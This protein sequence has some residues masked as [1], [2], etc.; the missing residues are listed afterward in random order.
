MIYVINNSNNPFFNHAAEEYLINEFNEEISM[1]WINRPSIL[2]GRNQNTISEINLDYVK[3]NNI[4]VVRRLSGG[5]TVF[6]DLGNM[7]FTFITFRNTSNQCIKNGFE[8][9]ALPVIHALKSLG[10]DATF[11]GRND[12]TIDG[13]KFSGNAQY[14]QKNKLLHHGTILYDCDMTKLS[15]A[16]KSKAVKF[17]D[18]SVK[19]VSSRVTNILP[20]METKMD[21]LEFREYLKNYIIK[22]NNIEKI[23]TFN[24]RD[25]EKIEKIMKERFE[26]WEW[27]YGESPVYT[28][29]NIVKYPCGVV[30]YS[31]NVENGVIKDISIYG[32]FFG[33]K[34]INDLELKLIGIKHNIEDIEFAIKEINIDR[35]IKG[36]SKTEFI[37]GL[38]DIYNTNV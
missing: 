24:R 20:Y 12:I 17:K 27:N 30:E 19:S 1:L 26:A 36:L 37:Q 22:S 33:E 34:N 21:L 6:N 16:L 13:K 8:K 32:D 25:I 2:I 5:G 28:C 31:L 14:F 15:Q 18:K 11:N 7:N 38:M 29:E 4:D 23:Y 35:Y 10:I 9:F 3:A